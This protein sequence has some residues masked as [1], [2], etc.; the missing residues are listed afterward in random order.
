MAAIFA[1]ASHA[2]LASVVFAFETTRQPLG[3]LPMLAGCAAAYLV[4]LL[5][6]RHS[7]M[8]EKL[9]RRGAIVRPEYAVDHLAQVLV[10]DVGLR[11]VVTLQA[12]DDL[13]TVR[14]W[15]ASGA[16][17]STHQGF[18]VLDAQKRLIGVLTRRDLL[19][20][21]NPDVLPV[22]AV[23]RRPPVVVYED[24][25]LRDA[26]DQM[27]IERVGRLPVVRRDAER[28]VVGIISRS[29][30]L[31]AHAPRLEAAHRAR[32][33]RSIWRPLEPAQPAGD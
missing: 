13:G 26:A 27:V 28:T 8:T 17:G 30:L 7:I 3:L 19:D 2:L 18:P 22:S 5:L 6:N 31:A 33:T 9:A 1:G 25:S 14:H 12:D 20:V 15:L 16:S 4:A 11:D 10:R 21:A 32:V 24:S 23:L 29:D